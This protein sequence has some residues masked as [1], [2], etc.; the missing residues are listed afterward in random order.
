MENAGVVR[1][2]EGA[3]ELSGEAGGGDWPEG[4]SLESVFQA[5]PF[6]VLEREIKADRRVLA[7]VVQR[8][9]VRMTH[10][11]RRAGLLSHPIE[12]SLDLIFRNREV[13]AEELDRDVSVEHR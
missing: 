3:P 13:V 2:R 11:R 9:D 7:H 4:S 5:A 6:Q 12:E 8:D 1:R 10:A